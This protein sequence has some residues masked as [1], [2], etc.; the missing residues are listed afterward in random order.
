VIATFKAYYL[1]RTFV[2]LVKSTD[3]DQVTVK[4]FWKAFTIRDAHCNIEESW[5]E[6][7][8]SCMNGVWGKPCPKFV[9]G[10]KD[11]SVNNDVLK[12]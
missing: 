7:N 9:H 10:F 1:R 11:F 3:N 4:D 8:R 5:K 6:V 12:A 2:N